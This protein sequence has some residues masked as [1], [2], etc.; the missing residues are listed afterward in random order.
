MTREE[1]IEKLRDDDHYYGDFGRQYRSNSDIKTLFDNPL[2]LGDPSPTNPFFLIGGYFHTAILEPDK[3]KKYKIVEASTRNTKKYKEISGG[4]MCLLQHEVD[5]V[6]ALVDKMMNNKI[7]RDLIVG[8]NIE[9]EQPSLVELYDNIWK[10]KADIVNHNEKLI[11]DLKTTS[12]LGKFQWN[13]KK[14]NYDSQAYIYRELFGYEFI[15]IA[16]D[17]NNGQIGL[18]DCSPDFYNTG[19]NKVERASEIYDLF[20]KSEDFDPAQYFINKTL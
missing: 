9:Y 3:I 17:K 16:I 7:C 6:E 10:G 20:Y 1:I 11:I 18:F 12:D 14:Y 5:K 15:F 13:A 4:E 2:S 8:D 19:K